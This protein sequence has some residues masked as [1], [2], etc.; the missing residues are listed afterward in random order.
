MSVALRITFE[1]TEPGLAQKRLSLSAFGEPFRL[2]LIAVQR[3]ASA[4]LSSALEDPAYGSHGGQY[5]AEA[6]LLDLEICGLADAEGSA[7]LELLCMARVP[8]GGQLTIGHAVP[9]SFARFDLA[10]L[11]IERLLQDIDAERRGTRRNAAVHRY[12]QSLPAG[13]TRQRYR[14]TCGDHVLGDVQ[15][16]GIEL[17]GNLT[18]Q[19]PVP[20]SAASPPDEPSLFLQDTKVEP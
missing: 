12:L 18:E 5:K 10:A 4:I 8:P 19:A 9:A 14:A 17:S 6:R 15:F 11:A 16:N 7:T 20:A 2:L 1:G 3:T 13:I